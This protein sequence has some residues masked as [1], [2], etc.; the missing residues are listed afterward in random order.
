MITSSCSI[1]QRCSIESGCQNSARRLTSGAERPDLRHAVERHYDSLALLYRLF[2]G[3][4]VHH[5]L[6]PARGGSPRDAQIR[7]VS[8]LADRA[9]IAGG[10]RVLDVGCGYGASAR[11]L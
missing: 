5:G 6:W 1:A 11:W 3:E 4:H 10:E 9:G 2:W 8:H 7:L